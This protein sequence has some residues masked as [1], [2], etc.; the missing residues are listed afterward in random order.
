MGKVDG[1]VLP[2][3]VALGIQLDEGVNVGKTLAVGTAVGDTLRVGAL[4]GIFEKD[5]VGPE[6]GSDETDGT[7][8]GADVG[9]A[10]QTQRRVPKK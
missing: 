6:D 4:D 1:E 2:V 5:T 10:N 7:N 3:G 9:G 8:D